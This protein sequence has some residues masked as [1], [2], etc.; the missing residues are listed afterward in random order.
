MA[1]L[2]AACQVIPQGPHEAPP[3]PAQGSAIALPR[4][5]ARHR[6]ALLVPLGAG[7]Q[8]GA[9]QA[10]ANAATMALLDTNADTIRITTYDTSAGVSAAAARAIADG[11]KLIL[12]PLFTEETQAVAMAARPAR[13]PVIAFANDAGLAGEN[14]FIMGTPPEQ[15]IA[16]VVRQARAA[17][18]QRFAALIP[19]GAYGTR[20]SSAMIE[21]V[22]ANGGT[23]VGM[24]GYERTPA[25]VQAAARRLKAHGPIDAVLVADEPR[26]A[27]DAASVLKAGNPQLRLL[28]TD[29]WTGDAAIARS[30][31]FNGALYAALSDQRYARFAESYKSRYGT[32]PHRIATLGYDSVLLTLR[33]ARDW[34]AGGPFPTARL[35]D[36]DG[37]LGL[38]GVFRFDVADVIQ[39]ALE[40]REVRRT[41]VAVV[42]PAPARFAN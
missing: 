26:V 21:A 12:G 8:A 25:S 42:S 30:P 29:L 38:D 35:F 4:D 24:E 20:A 28:G 37:F 32:A 15:P 17:G 33:L 16:R 9:G 11:N 22:R 39:R 1:G 10:I 5:G 40:V 3:P 41:G 6:V 23:L 36:H 2:L 31:L 7:G 19:H 14:L 27:I 13:V 34:P 18:V